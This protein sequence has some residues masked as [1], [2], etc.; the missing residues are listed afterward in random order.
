MARMIPPSRPVMART[1]NAQALY[2]QSGKSISLEIKTD[3]PSVSAAVRPNLVADAVH[4]CL[5]RELAQIRTAFAT[6]TEGLLPSLPQP[7]EQVRPRVRLPY[8]TA[9]HEQRDWR[10]KDGVFEVAATHQRSL[11]DIRLPEDM[12]ERAVVKALL[13]QEC[14]S[15]LQATRAVYETMLE[16]VLSGSG[17]ADR[18]RS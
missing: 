16:Q 7:S 8:S 2:A 1:D 18:N 13:D 14:Q 9:F 6:L 5:E 17:D 4:Q 3:L 15:R 10:W 11:V 12:S